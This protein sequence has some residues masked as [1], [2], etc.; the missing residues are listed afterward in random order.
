MKI[1]K[2]Q[3]IFLLS[4][5]FFIQACTLDQGS[6]K[7]VAQTNA[8]TQVDEFKEEILKELITYKKKLDLRNPN[9]YNKNLQSSIIHEII[10][11]RN[12]INLVQNGQVLEKSNEYFYYA[13]SPKKIENRNDLLILG[14]YKMIYKAFM[15]EENHQF[16][17]ISYNQEEM[18]KLYEYLQVVRWKIRTAKD[19]NGDYLFNTWQNNWQLELAKKYQGDYNII[20]DLLY[21]KANRETVFDSSNFS[22]E[23]V[24]SK[25]I[26][27]VEHTLR[28]I[29]VE[30]YEMSLTA[31]KSFIFII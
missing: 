31:L 16:S 30:P 14:L 6:I 18:K 2:V 25:M 12:F 29:N 17:A 5:S 4:L 28:K 1:N 11:K 9:A 7:S 22:Y 13:F 27:N 24:F 19:E 20:N 10:T 3:V 21:I 26:T 23:I 15:M 8:A